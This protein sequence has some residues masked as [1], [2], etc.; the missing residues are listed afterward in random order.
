MVWRPVCASS[1]GDILW[2][3]GQNCV[4]SVGNISWYG[5]KYVPVVLEIYYGVEAKSVSVRL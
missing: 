2:Y 4:S 5:G 3:G 1:V